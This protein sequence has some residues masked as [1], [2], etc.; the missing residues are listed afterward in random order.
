MQINILIGIGAGL[1]SAM[2]F[3]SASTGTILG[4]FVLFFLS[5]MPVAIAGLGWGWRAAAFSTVAAAAAIGLI[6]TPR[7]ALFHA[8]A[9]GAP[10]TVLSYLTLLNRSIVHE[11]GATS[12]EWYPL[13]RIVALAA[14]IAGGLATVG[15]LSSA[16]DVEQLRTL[17]GGTLERMFKRPAGTVLPS[18][19]P[20][21]LSPEQMTNLTNVVIGMFTAS[22]ATMWFAVAMLNMWL[23]AHVVAKSDRLVR[24]WPDLSGLQ[25]P[26]AT[27]MALAASLAGTFLPG[28]PGLIAAGFAV[29]LMMAYVFVGLAIV[30][31]FT[32]GST[33][34][35]MILTGIYVVLILLPIIAGPLLTLLG[36]A[37]P[38]S[39]WR[40][41]SPPAGPAAT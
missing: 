24:P 18:G 20:E 26:P 15:L 39:P 17:L 41:G 13:G 28:F 25:L 5:P 22:L 9:I 27:P 1:V 12:T 38:F 11:D 30:H 33:L 29:A 23:A 14:L 31:R 35:P 10:T 4:L 2:L 3:A 8:L 21:A 6:G 16:T 34:R 40:R 36:L 32:R 37:E 7:G 19:M